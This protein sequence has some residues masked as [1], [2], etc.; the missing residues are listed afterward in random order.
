MGDSLSRH[1]SQQTSAATTPLTVSK[2]T[3]PAGIRTSSTRSYAFSSGSSG[4]RDGRS[5]AGRSTSSVLQSPA[6]VGSTVP[7][8]RLG[9]TPV[10]SRTRF[11]GG[12]GRTGLLPPVRVAKTASTSTSSATSSTSF[13]STPRK[14]AASSVLAASAAAARRS[15]VA[16]AVPS[17]AGKSERSEQ[18]YSTL[19]MSKRPAAQQEEQ[20]VE[21]EHHDLLERLKRESL[22]ET[23]G[24]LHAV[25]LRHVEDL[26]YFTKEDFETMRIKKDHAQKLVLLSHQE[27][28]ARRTRTY[29][30]A[31][32]TRFTIGSRKYS[33]IRWFVGS[34]ER[35]FCACVIVRSRK[36]EKTSSTPYLPA[37]SPAFNPAV[38][39][40][41]VFP[42]LTLNPELVAP[43]PL[44]LR[45]LLSDALYQRR[46]PN[47]ADQRETQNL[48]GT[49][50]YGRA[51]QADRTHV[52]SIRI[53]E[54]G[55]AA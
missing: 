17:A 4:R 47:R 38:P 44:S 42:R 2:D 43:L 53:S 52:R 14:G 48:Q 27:P 34:I 35:V 1:R 36:F 33:F 45:I 11:G 41:S 32:K 21:E 40:I 55:L 46:L 16:D 23:F 31:K 7:G 15:N 10:A 49:L 9:D 8:A 26:A 54:H 20:H 24:V 29:A 12:S 25:G 3:A 22:Q 50:P 13:E 30:A 28:V 39:R 37:R 19:L 5:T 6:G 51:M 18:H